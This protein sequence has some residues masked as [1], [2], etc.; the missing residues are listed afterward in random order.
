[1]LFEGSVTSAG[2]AK[3]ADL[4]VSLNSS[5]YPRAFVLSE[6]SAKACCSF[7][8]PPSTTASAEGALGCD[9]W[10][11]TGGAWR[12]A[13]CREWT[14]GRLWVSTCPGRRRRVNIGGMQRT[15]RGK[16][17]TPVLAPACHRHRRQVQ[18]KLQR[19]QGAA[20]GLLPRRATAPALQ[21]RCS[22]QVKGG[23]IT[24]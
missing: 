3:I 21:V 17:G 2:Q 9:H 22:G 12:C 6:R 5:A 4:F 11:A 1:M 19:D 8:Q 14:A 10:A 13:R 20:V 23:R 7:A 24:R 18:S 15:H 16:F